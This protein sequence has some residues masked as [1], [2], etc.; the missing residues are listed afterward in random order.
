MDVTGGH[1]N[2]VGA[3]FGA[4]VHHMG[5]ALGIKVG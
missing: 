5:L 2:T 3:G 4:N 1:R